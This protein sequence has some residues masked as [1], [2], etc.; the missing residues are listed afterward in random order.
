MA[1][2]KDNSYIQVVK[3]YS[4]LILLIVFIIIASIAS[5]SFL[6]CQISLTSCSRRGTG[7]YCDRQDYL[8]YFQAA[9]TFL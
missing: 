5:D 6:R 8:R 2:L 4:V 3:R 7:H 1:R 9:Q